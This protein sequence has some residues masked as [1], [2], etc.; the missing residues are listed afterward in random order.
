MMLALNVNV[1]TGQASK[2]IAKKGKTSCLGKAAQV[3]RTIFSFRSTFV[4]ILCCTV[5]WFSDLSIPVWPTTKRPP[6]TQ[7]PIHS[8]T[9]SKRTEHPGINS[10]YI[11]IQDHPPNN[12]LIKRCI[13]FASNHRWTLW[14]TANYW[15][16][17]A[18]NYDSLI[19]IYLAGSYNSAFRWASNYD[20][21]IGLAG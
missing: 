20:S 11:L 14:L 4:V 2:E 13:W 8:W 9:N 5:F 16:W 10:M 21:A 18:N 7:L 6:S 12:L 17:L 19:W 1:I 15:F 3:L